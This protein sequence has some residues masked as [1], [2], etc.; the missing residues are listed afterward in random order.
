MTGSSARLC[1]VCGVVVPANFRYC[2]FCSSVI[3]VQPSEAER[4]RAELQAELGEGIELH[5]RIG[6]GGYGM[7][8]RATDHSAPGGRQVAVKVLHATLGESPLMRERFLRGALV[9][10]DF[11][12]PHILPVHE[13]GGS[14]V[15]SFIV[16]PFVEG[17]SLAALLLRE[18]RLAPA[19]A[20]RILTEAGQALAAVHAAGYVYRDVK[21]QHILL[22]GPA[23]RVLLIDF[24]LVCA[25]GVPESAPRPRRTV[26]GPEEGAVVGTPA[27]MSPEQAEGRFDVDARSDVYSLGVVAYQ[28]LTGV[29]PFEGSAQQQMVAHRTRTSRNP[30]V[31][32]QDIRADLADVVMR[33][34]SKLRTNRWASAADFVAALSLP[35]SPPTPGTGVGGP[36]S[37]S[38]APPPEPPGPGPQAPDPGLQAPDPGLQAPDPGSVRPPAHQR[39]VVRMLTLP[40]PPPPPPPPPLPPPAAPEPPPVVIYPQRERPRP[41]VAARRPGEPGRPSSTRTA[42]PEPAPPG[43]RRNVPLWTA[44]VIVVLLLGYA[45]VQGLRRPTPVPVTT[46]DTAAVST[47]AQ[48]TAPLANPGFLTVIVQPGGRVFVDGVAVGSAPLTRYPIAPGRHRV[49][50]ERAGYRPDSLV[51]Q[52]RA[53]IAVESRVA[54]TPR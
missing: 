21:P 17:E 51:V 4:Q 14:G 53:G 46:R 49:R 35:P 30:A 16:M 41:S 3:P 11:D 20:V 34:L 39:P 19:E 22:R 25:S 13:I 50:I 45:A 42:A 23:R 47:T 8:F 40:P 27:Y 31:Q 38:A 7:V 43:S 52:V 6:R 29:V 5:E 24:S 54:L 37:V 2:P 12:H 33:A 15:V 10:G 44:G 32:H 9:Q 26:P 36:G 48:P 28:L 18:G 1:A